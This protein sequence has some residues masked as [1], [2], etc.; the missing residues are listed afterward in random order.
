MFPTTGSYEICNICGWEDD[1]SQETDPTTW[2]GANE[3]SLNEAKDYWQATGK[4][5]K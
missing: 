1:E 5:I 2:G 4:R 3:L